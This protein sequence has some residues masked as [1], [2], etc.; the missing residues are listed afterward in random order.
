MRDREIIVAPL[1]IGMSIRIKHKLSFV[2]YVCSCFAGF[3]AVNDDG[4]VLRMYKRIEMLLHI[5]G[6]DGDE[7]KLLYIF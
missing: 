2:S 5:V 3:M 7:I 4:D 6:V 1:Y